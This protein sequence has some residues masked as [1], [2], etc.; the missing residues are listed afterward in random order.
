MD[1]HAIDWTDDAWAAA[2][3]RSLGTRVQS[4]ERAGPLTP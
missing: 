3:K 4:Y 2:A 1:G